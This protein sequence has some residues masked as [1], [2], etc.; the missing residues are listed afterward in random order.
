MPVT[1]VGYRAD[2][3]ATG[4]VWVLPAAVMVMVRPDRLTLI[5]ESFTCASRNG[6]AGTHPV[7]PLGRV[8]STTCSQ[9]AVRSSTAIVSGTPYGVRPGRDAVT[10]PVGVGSSR[11]VID[12]VG[13]VMTAIVPAWMRVVVVVGVVGVVMAAMVAT[14]VTVMPYLMPMPMTAWYRL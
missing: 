5:I 9:L 6:S 10:L 1:G 12:V 11:A 14:V 13:L 2:P 8:G 3:T 4:P 7:D